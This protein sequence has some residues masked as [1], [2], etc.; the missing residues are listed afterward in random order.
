MLEPLKEESLAALVPDGGDGGIPS[1]GIARRTLL[2]NRD[3]AWGLSNL[4]QPWEAFQSKLLYNE[5]EGAWQKRGKWKIGFRVRISNI[6]RQFQ[7]L[8]KCTATP[9]S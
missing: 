5:H 4:F 3:L 6:L 1:L 7:P 9:V 2:E 8:I